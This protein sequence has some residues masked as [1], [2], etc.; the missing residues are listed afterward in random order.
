MARPIKIKINVTRILKEYIF[1]G[2]NGKY[3]NLVAWP[4]KNGTGQYGD[5]HFVSQDIPKEARDEG[6]QAPILGN[7][8]LPEDEAPA[9]QQPPQK[10]V[11]HQQAPPR[12]SPPGTIEYPEG[13]IAD[14]MEDSDIPF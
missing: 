10:R 1:E 11:I 13:P 14:G 9:R 8:T 4:N 3:L 7:L 6:V 2:K 5:T 12:L